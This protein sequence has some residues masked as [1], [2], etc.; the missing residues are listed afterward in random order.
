MCEACPQKCDWLV[1]N[2]PL[3]LQEVSSHRG[4]PVSNWPARKQTHKQNINAILEG[5]KSTVNSFVKSFSV[6]SLRFVPGI[7]AMLPAQTIN[8]PMEYLYQS[9][10]HLLRVFLLVCARHICIGAMLSAQ[11]INFPMEYLYQSR[12]ITGQHWIRHNTD[13]VSM[14]GD[15]TPATELFQVGQGELEAEV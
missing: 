5:N 4:H 8:F 14:T 10:I 15:C 7:G 11:T 9:R 6:W 3:L 2:S 12:S 1:R 13:S